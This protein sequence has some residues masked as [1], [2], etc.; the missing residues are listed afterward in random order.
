M[1]H[2]IEEG[3]IC[4]KGLT[5]ESAIR[6]L[7]ILGPFWHLAPFVKMPPPPWTAPDTPVQAIMYKYKPSPA[8]MCHIA[9]VTS[10]DQDMQLRWSADW[11][12]GQE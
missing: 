12:M 10:R 2:F 8:R 1:K 3:F 5:M 7:R 4:R 6:E 9:G 11:L